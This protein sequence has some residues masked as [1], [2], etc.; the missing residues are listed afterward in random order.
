MRMSNYVGF[1]VD[2]AV[3]LVLD[4]LRNYAPFLFVNSITNKF[5]YGVCG[6]FQIVLN[7]F[8][9]CS[10]SV[11]FVDRFWNVPERCESIPRRFF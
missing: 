6:L 1:G 7:R 2:G 8:L 11:N 10:M 3:S 9:Q 5:W 4:N